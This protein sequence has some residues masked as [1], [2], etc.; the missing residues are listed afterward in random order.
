MFKTDRSIA[1]SKTTSAG[2]LMDCSITGQQ[3][4][5]DQRLPPQQP[6][7]PPASR[8]IPVPQRQPSSG[9]AADVP[10]PPQRSPAQT[11]QVAPVPASVHVAV[12]V[13]VM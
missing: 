3:M 1:C 6:P 13:L 5:H 2:A 8:P 4:Q 9:S 10:S 11:T 7:R 12:D